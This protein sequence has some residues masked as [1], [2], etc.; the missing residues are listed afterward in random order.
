VATGWR[1]RYSNRDAL[2]EM[3]AEHADLLVIGPLRTRRSHVRAVAAA[4]LVV[5]AGAVAVA[6]R[7]RLRARRG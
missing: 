7:R 2:A 3:A 1:P 6:A 4:T 5:A